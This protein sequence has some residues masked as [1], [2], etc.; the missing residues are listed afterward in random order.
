MN[1]FQPIQDAPNFIIADMLDGDNIKNNLMAAN[2]VPDEYSGILPYINVKGAADAIE[3]YKSAFGAVEVGRISLA[4]GTVAHCELRIGNGRFMLAEESLRWGNKSPMTLGGTPVAL[5]FYVDD[6]DEVF[7]MA[8]DEGARVSGN[9]EVK[10]QF[11]G[12]RAG[13]LTDPF[14]HQWTIMTHI[15]DVTFDEMQKRSDIMFA[16][17]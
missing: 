16:T 9:M 8:L 12:D 7:N 15:E 4:D 5:C 10:D 17:F 3:F 1:I 13:T 2:K 11:Y 14:G 6:V